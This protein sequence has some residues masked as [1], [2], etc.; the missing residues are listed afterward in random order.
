MKIVYLISFLLLFNIAY[1]DYYDNKIVIKL[2]ENFNRNSQY[3]KVLSSIDK[4]VKIDNLIDEKILSQIS[5]KN[6]KNLN[7]KN[8]NL[9]RIYVA[10][11]SKSFDILTLSRKINNLLQVEYA[12]P[13]FK[14]QI[15]YIPNDTLLYEQYYLINTYIYDAWKYMHDNNLQDSMLSK[16]ILVGVVDTGIDFEHIELKNMIFTNL[17]EFGI[18]E[19][20]QDKSTNGIDDDENSFIDDYRGWDFVSDSSELGY[21]NNPKYGHPHGTH[22]SGIISAENNNTAGIAGIGINMKILPV[23][24]GADSYYSTSV[25]NSYDGVLYAAL[26]GADVINCS[27]GGTGYSQSEQDIIN[28]ATDMGSLVIAAA[29]NSGLNA[30][31]YPASYKNVISVAATNFTDGKTSFTNAHSTVDISAPGYEIISTIPNDGY[32]SWSGTSMAAPVVAAIAGW[33]IR[34]FPDASPFKI[35]EILKSTSSKNERN[36]DFYPGL[37]GAGIVNMYKVLSDSTFYSAEVINTKVNGKDDTLEYG[38]TLTLSFDFANYLSDLQNVDISIYEPNVEYLQILD[39]TI[40]IDS[41]RSGEV[42]SFYDKIKFIINNNSQIDQIVTLV[43]KTK[44]DEYSSYFS[45][46]FIINPSFKNFENNNIKTTFN[47]QGNIAFNNYSANTQ[48]IGLKYLA[49]ENLLFEGAFIA[50]IPNKINDVA[51]NE[52]GSSKN[53]DFLVDEI[54]NSAILGNNLIGK[55]KYYNLPDSNNIGISIH[56]SI[57]QSNEYDDRNTIYLKYSAINNSGEFQDS[58]YLG[59]YFDWDIG[60][61]GQGNKVILNSDYYSGIVYNALQDTLQYAAV[62]LLNER[63]KFNFYAIDNPGDDTTSF[64]V[65][66]GF[67]DAEKWQAIST[68]IGRAES[69]IT[70]ASFVISAGPFS[71]KSQDTVN[72]IFAVSVA[73]K[74]QQLE[75]ILQNINQQKFFDDDK[76]QD[77]KEFQILNIFPN[78]AADKIT[79]E[80]MINILNTNFSI[81]IYDMEGKFI[82]NLFAG[83][84]K[85]FGLQRIESDI[86]KLSQGKYMI[87]ISK[88]NEIIDSAT[89]V[90]IK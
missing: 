53:R 11:F 74:M 8:F 3:Y 20:G 26:L 88:S 42:L 31:Q 67:S 34:R 37:L 59:L 15:S 47:S 70:D 21:D 58:L 45:T 38:D 18:D 66:D 63:D 85:Y 14:R 52:S 71:V 12:E 19:N 81:S 32:D 36:D 84:S 48:G 4:N 6:A 17:G 64:S 27:W 28:S 56:Q 73:E 2:N 22:V 49:S 72:V 80:I 46:D 86:S 54:I 30:P 87:C 76:L 65:Y 78:P 41:I 44:S 82:K 68:Q 90:I 23:K 33:A 60:P 7:N 61:S 43:I 77:A 25:Q 62:T 51:R 13:L 57:V 69:S 75:E 24:V 29:G 39:N 1:S 83:K 89:L 35:G 16:E 40:I 79:V 50:A 10:S 55:T 9:D 5:N